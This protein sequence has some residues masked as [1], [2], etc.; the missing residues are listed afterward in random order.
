MS[1]ENLGVYEV[2]P[3]TGDGVDDCALLCAVS[4]C[5]ESGEKCGFCYACI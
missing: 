3:R 5:S 4:R 1:I 2:P